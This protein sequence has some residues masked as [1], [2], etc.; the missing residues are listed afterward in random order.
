[1]TFSL[2][3]VAS[4]R[5]EWTK[6]AYSDSREGTPRLGIAL[7]SKIRSPP[8]SPSPTGQEFLSTAHLLHSV[9]QMVYPA[10]SCSLILLSANRRT[11]TF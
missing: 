9:S 5:G 7:C 2:S 11:V 6:K 3:T 8:D 1:M 10:S 4:L